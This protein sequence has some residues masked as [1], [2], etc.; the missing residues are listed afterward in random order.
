MMAKKVIAEI[1][2]HPRLTDGLHTTFKG[3]IFGR[4][5]VLGNDFKKSK[6]GGEEEGANGEKDSDYQK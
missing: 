5:W 6:G 2:L 3:S 4:I 1:K